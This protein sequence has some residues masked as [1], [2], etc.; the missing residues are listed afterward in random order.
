M[1]LNPYARMSA[2]LTEETRDSGF[3][4]ERVRRDDQ[5]RYLIV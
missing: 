4:P 1:P 3:I 2:A 5:V